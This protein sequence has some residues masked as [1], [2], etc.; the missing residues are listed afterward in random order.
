VSINLRKNNFSLAV[1]IIL[2]SLAIVTYVKLFFTRSPEIVIQDAKIESAINLKPNNYKFDLKD[3]P[4]ADRDLD[5]ITIDLSYKLN[6]PS[7]WW[8]DIDTVSPNYDSL[9]QKFHGENIWNDPKLNSH[10][11]SLGIRGNANPFGSPMALDNGPLKNKLLETKPKIFMEVGVFEGATSSKVAQLFKNTPGFEESYVI[12]VDSWIL[13]LTYEWNGQKSVH[14]KKVVNKAR[15]F[16]NDRIAG[17]SKMYYQFLANCIERK[18]QDRIIPLPTATSNGALAMLSHGVR[19][20]FMYIDAS[21]ANPDVLIDYE[22]FYT[23][24]QPGGVMV[25]DDTHVPAVMAALTFLVER[26]GLTVVNL[27]HQQGYIVK[28]TI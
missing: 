12:S 25:F 24:L 14:K 17:G 26:Y 16:A 20:D 7:N 10:F 22:N 5:G 2:L 4:A 3:A 21:H 23:I 6:V 18:S 28:P 8:D 15:Y 19:P 27:K 9:M 1:T 11:E 13:D